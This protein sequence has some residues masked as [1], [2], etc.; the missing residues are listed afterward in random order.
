MSCLRFPSVSN[1]NANSREN[2]TYL[3]NQPKNEVSLTLAPVPTQFPPVTE[4]Y[5]YGYN[6]ALYKPPRRENEPTQAEEKRWK[7]V[8]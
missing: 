7:G 6:Y 3:R 2:Y 8:L 5:Q 4:N 1:S